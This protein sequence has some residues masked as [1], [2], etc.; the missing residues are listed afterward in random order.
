M[1]IKNRDSPVVYICS[2]YSGDVKRNTE[3]ARRYCR[4]AVDQGCIPL[5]PHLILP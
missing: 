2:R 1:K 5:A 3:M 4:Y